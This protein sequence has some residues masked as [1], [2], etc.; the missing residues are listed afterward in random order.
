MARVNLRELGRERRH[1]RLRKKIFGTAERP[2]LS[3][4]KSCRHVHAQLI[5]DNL[6]QTLVYATTLHK[7]LK[8]KGANSKSAKAVG[9]MI[10]QKASEK[11]IQKAVFDR[12]GYPY[13][14]VVKALADGAREGGLKF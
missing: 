13:H 12:G 3:V 14:G 11:G 8:A 5:D 2:R 10:A 6:G 7:E 9:K 4:Y 1:A